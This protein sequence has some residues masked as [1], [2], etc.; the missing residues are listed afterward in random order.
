V[1]PRR[2]ELPPVP[3]NHSRRI[4]RTEM[5]CFH[6][7]NTHF[8]CWFCESWNV[9]FFGPPSSRSF[10]R[11]FDRPNSN[12]PKSPKSANLPVLI[13]LLFLCQKYSNLGPSSMYFLIQKLFELSYHN[14]L[15]LE[16]FKFQ[17][18]ATFADVWFQPPLSSSS[19]CFLYFVWTFFDHSYP[20]LLSKDIFNFQITESQ[21]LMS[22]PSISSLD[23]KIFGPRPENLCSPIPPPSCPKLYVIHVIQELYVEMSTCSGKNSGPKFY[24]WKFFSM[25]PT[26]PKKTHAPPV[27]R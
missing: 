18:S 5:N 6:I 14:Y 26:T 22:L 20:A 2:L 3:P 16:M 9:D 7:H 21:H 4:V 12:F 23:H 8:G 27:P 25:T 1:V 10:F 17:P 11:E 19:Q 24:C 13:S 15:F